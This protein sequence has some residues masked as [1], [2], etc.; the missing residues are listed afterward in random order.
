M[1]NTEQQ[2]E[3]QRQQQTSQ[4]I[5]TQLTEQNIYHLTKKQDAVLLLITSPNE[6]LMDF[7]N[8]LTA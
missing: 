1:N 3:T 7:H 4:K 2:Q 6:I 5:H 8:S